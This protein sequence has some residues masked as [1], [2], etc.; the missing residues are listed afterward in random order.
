M[1]INEIKTIT[2][3]GRVLE[4]KKSGVEVGK[5]GTTKKIVQ[6]QKVVPL[7]R[8]WWPP[9]LHFLKINRSKPLSTGFVYATGRT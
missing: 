4:L 7:K 2:C 8:F 9:V 1:R 3:I 6:K 5:M